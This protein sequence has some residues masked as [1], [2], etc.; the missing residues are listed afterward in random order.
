MVNTTRPET[1]LND[2]EAAALP[3]DHVPSRD[4]D[5]VEGDMAMAVRCVVVAVDREHAV[6]CDTVGVG[7]DQDHGLLAVRVLVSAVK[8][9]HDDV[10][11]AA[12]VTGTGG[13]P[14]LD[15]VSLRPFCKDHKGRLTW[16]L[17]TYS[18]PSL[19]MLISIFLASLEAT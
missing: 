19:R 11:G 6:D 9:A 12:G 8:L 13:P 3:E 15:A 4:A 17:R 10:D 5:V 16:P 1:A 2:L 18:S 14:F 7:G